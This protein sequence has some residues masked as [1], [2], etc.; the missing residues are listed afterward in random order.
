MVYNI[1]RPLLFLL[2][3]VSQRISRGS[4][5][6]DWCSIPGNVRDLRHGFPRDDMS[7]LVLA[8]LSGTL[9]SLA[10]VFS[11]LTFDSS[12][13]FLESFMLRQICSDAQ[14]KTCYVVS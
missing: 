1:P 2:Q 10:S 4:R 13:N 11:K 3:N 7:G 12:E 14:S 8:S 5:Q 6:P 9:A